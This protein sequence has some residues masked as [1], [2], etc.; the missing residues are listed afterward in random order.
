[1]KREKRPAGAEDFA[2][3]DTSIPRQALPPELC[4]HVGFMLGKARQELA[5]R[6]DPLTAP[7]TIRHFGLLLLVIKRGAMRQTDL[8]DLVRLDRTTMMNM[9]DELE[10]SGFVRREAD[11]NDRRANAVT[12]TPAGKRWLEK[13]RPKAEEIERAFLSPLKAA[14]QEQLRVLLTRLVSP[15]QEN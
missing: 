2:P 1:M 10:Q 13:L 5:L 7:L 9:V 11:P 14:E 12:A 3:Y 8:A 6:L 4:E 15:E